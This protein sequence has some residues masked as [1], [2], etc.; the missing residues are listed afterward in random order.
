[1]MFGWVFHVNFDCLLLGKNDPTCEDLFLS[2]DLLGI[3]VHHSRIFFF[4]VTGLCCEGPSLTH[5]Y[6]RDGARLF[7]H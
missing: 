5:F 3:S 2:D 6:K 4:A 1:M 7:C